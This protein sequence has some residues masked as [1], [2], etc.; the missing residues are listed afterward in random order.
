MGVE[1]GGSVYMNKC[2]DV[3]LWMCGGGWISHINYVF[4]FVHLSFLFSLCYLCYSSRD[5]II[6]SVVVE[7]ILIHVFFNQF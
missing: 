4:I 6:Q 5:L 3:Y 2:M 7:Y 1:M